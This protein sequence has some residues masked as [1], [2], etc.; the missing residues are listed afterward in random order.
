MHQG[1]AFNADYR[2]TWHRTASD[3]SVLEKLKVFLRSFLKDFCDACTLFY[4]TVHPNRVC[5]HHVVSGYLQRQ[6]R[7]SKRLRTHSSACHQPLSYWEQLTALSWKST[8]ASSTLSIDIKDQR[9]MLIADV[10]VLKQTAKPDHDVCLKSIRCTEKRAK[11]VR[12]PYS[13]GLG[14]RNHPV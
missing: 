8:W 10:N 13:Y 1:P 7:V 9:L 12:V 11:F 2:R 6:D 3:N 4:T 14:S 5:W